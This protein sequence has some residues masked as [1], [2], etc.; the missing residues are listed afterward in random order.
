VSV[1][2]S[3]TGHVDVAAGPGAITDMQPQTWQ[4]QSLMQKCTEA[5]SSDVASAL[6]HKRLRPI[7]A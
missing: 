5:T 6:N 7:A 4:K 1:T 2:A 3:I